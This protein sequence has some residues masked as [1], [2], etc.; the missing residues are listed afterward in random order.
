[1]IELS[2]PQNELLHQIKLSG[3]RGTLKSTTFGPAENL[4]RIGYARWERKLDNGRM[5]MLVITS[6]GVAA[7]NGG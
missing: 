2:A 1:M 4:V 5:G 7:V 3:Q 6:K